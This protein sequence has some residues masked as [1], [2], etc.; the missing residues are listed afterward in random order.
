MSHA[1]SGE[2]QIPWC[3]DKIQRTAVG[4]LLYLR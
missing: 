1:E 2:L 4:R 3:V